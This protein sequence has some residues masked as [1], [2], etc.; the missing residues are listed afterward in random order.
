MALK[1]ILVHI[2]NTQHCGVMLDLAIGLAQKHKAHLTGLFVISRPHYRPEHGS[3]EL[4]AAEAQRIFQRKTAQAGISAHWLC[5][6]STVS[7]VSMAQLINAH[8]Y[9]SDLVMVG[10]S[11]H[12]SRVGDMPSDLPEKL[13][14]GS[15]RPVLIVPFAGKFNTVGE[16]IMVAWKAGREST[17]AVHDALYFLQDAKHVGVLIVTPPGVES[18][19]KPSRTDVCAHLARLDISAK[20][21]EVVG[22]D[23][24]VGDVLLN[25]AWE[26]GCDLL[27]T[28]AY[29]HSSGGMVLS[30]VASHILKHMTMPVLMSH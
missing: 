13:V 7:G 14:L 11:D 6:D 16:R 24:P 12:S 18:P 8:A 26:E 1:D 19:T 9:T 29:T 15:G 10:Q 3:A 20:M 4:E 27:V 30:P 28:G 17:R 25:Q 2:D 22:A 21:D 5:D 23:I